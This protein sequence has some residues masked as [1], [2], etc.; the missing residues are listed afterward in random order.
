MNALAHICPK[1][2]DFV[3]FKEEF[4]TELIYN[5]IREIAP[6]TIVSFYVC[7][8]LGGYKSC[9]DIFTPVLTDQGL[10]YSF[11]ALNSHEIYTDE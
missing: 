5:I 10:C 7:F 6:P 3:E 1:L 11:N 4:A 2:S 9:S 8:W